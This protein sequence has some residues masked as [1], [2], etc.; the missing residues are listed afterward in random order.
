MSTADA[1]A[2]EAAWLATSGDGLPALLTANGGP[3][4]IIQPYQR[5]T[6][7][8]EKTAIYVWRPSF[9]DPR[10]AN[11][12]LRPMYDFQ[13][14]LHWPV[15]QAA[16]GIAEAEQQALD[17][18]VDLLIVRIRGPLLDKTHGG[19]F[20]SVGEVPRMPGVHVA[21]DDPEITIPQLKALKAVV[22]YS[23]DDLEV[24]D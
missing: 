3:W 6:P 21:F 7:P 2:R 11:I 9:T 1:V 24:N 15:R 19:R 20:L 8:S 5:R 23:A 17:N 14:K 12:R 13:L 4:D 10:V 18:A 16:E 22:S